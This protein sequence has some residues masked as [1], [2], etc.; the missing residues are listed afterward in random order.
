MGPS[1][2]TNSSEFIL[3]ALEMSCSFNLAKNGSSVELTNDV[4]LL[5]EK[6]TA[7]C[8][9][10]LILPAEFRESFFE[11]TSVESFFFWENGAYFFISGGCNGGWSESTI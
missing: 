7:K 8:S 6:K 1:I 4:D 3:F 2:S 11:L 9:I 10:Y 5:S